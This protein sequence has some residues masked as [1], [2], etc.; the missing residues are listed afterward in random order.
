M[1]MILNSATVLYTIIYSYETEQNK[2][3]YLRV[4]FNMMYLICWMYILSVSFKIELLN[5]LL[6]IL[7]K[8]EPFSDLFL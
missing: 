7:D 4:F 5:T 2:F 3:K 1:R 6:N 8:I